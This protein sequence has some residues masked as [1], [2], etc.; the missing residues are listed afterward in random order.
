MD[1]ALKDKVIRIVTLTLLSMAIAG[2]IC[3]FLPNIYEAEAVLM[4]RDPYKLYQGGMVF[5]DN[6]GRNLQD[7]DLPSMSVK[8]VENLL[9]S[10]EI[11]QEI[12]DRMHLRDRFTEI[13]VT[14]LQKK[15]LRVRLIPGSTSFNQTFY[16]PAITLVAKWRYKELVKDIA[17][18]WAQVIVEKIREL[19]HKTIDDAIALALQNQAQIKDKLESLSSEME[20]L[21]Q[22]Q[23][24]DPVE[25]K[26][27]LTRLGKDLDELKERSIMINEYVNKITLLK[28]QKGNSGAIIAISAIEPT[29][30][31]KIFPSRW[32]IVLLSG[33]FSFLF[34][35]FWYI[36]KEQFIAH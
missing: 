30:R 34:S 5:S 16:E 29:V 26:N 8:T 10:S 12:I 24:G 17:N 31:D 18:C 6:P 35:T 1:G 33:L 23:D 13:S 36:F 9:K 22:K 27:R 21:S 25:K 19:N 14:Y 2:I 32:L 3:P 15:V 11:V 28:I 4:F 7:F 20:I